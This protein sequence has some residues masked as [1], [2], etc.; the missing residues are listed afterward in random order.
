MAQ[1]QASTVAGILTTTGNVGIGITNPTARLQA[2]G[3]TSYNT[4]ITAAGNTSNG[5]GLGLLNANGH[6]WYL[7]S[8]GTGNGGGANNLGFYDATAGDYRVYF[9]GDGNVGINTT[10]PIQDLHVY[11]A[12]NGDG[13]LIE[14]DPAGV[15]RA[16]ALKLYPKAASANERNWAISPYK[17]VEQSLSFASSN[18]KGGDPYSA[19]TTRMIID[20]I[21]GNVGIGTATPVRDLMIG[22]LSSVSTATPKT[23]SLGGTYSNSAGENIKLR[24][25]EEPSA[26]GGMSVSGG[27][28]E[29]NTWSS[30]KIAFYRGTTQSMIIDTSGNVGIGTNNPRTDLHV[31]TGTTGNSVEAA[32]FT[33]AYAATGDGPLIR[34]TNFLSFATNPNTAEYNLAGI[35]AYDFASNWGGALQF[36]TAVQTGGGGNLTAAMTIDQTQQVGI[37]TVTPGY[38]FQVYND[39]DIWHTVIGGASG[40]LRIG[41]QTSSGAV[42]QALTPA[43]G[44]RDLYLQRDGGS[45][46]IGTNSPTA[47]LQINGAGGDTAPSLRIISAASDTFNWATD[48]RYA[49]LTVGETAIH[50]IGKANSQYNQAYFGYRH[51]SDG[52]ASNMLTLGMYA[53]DYLVNV[54]GN[55]NVGIGYTNP[56]YKLQVNGTG[57]FNETLFV[58]GI[59][60]IEDRMASIYDMFTGG[61]VGELRSSTSVAGNINFQGVTAQGAGATATTQQ[62][63]TWDINNY[64]GT[65]NYGVQA[66]LVVGNNGNVGT[67][68]GFFTS[69]NYGA[70]PVERLRIQAGGNV[71]I[72][73]TSPAYKLD[74][75]G[76]FRSN[77]LFTDASA[78]AFWGNGNT[79]TSY[80]LLT[81]DTG[82]A[83]VFATSGNRLDLGANGTVAA[84]INTSGNVGIGTTVPSTK[85]EVG[86]FLDTV[87]NKITVSARYEYEP[88]FNFKLGQSGTNF[89]WIG[90]VISS[91][92][93]D[94]YNGKILFKTAN[95]GRDTPTTKMVIKANGNVGIGT[96]APRKELDV[97]GNNL[98]V[99]A[100]R[101]ILGED[102]YSTS[103][104]YIG[105]KTSFQ[106]GTT[107]Y[108]IISGKSDGATYVSAKA[109]SPVYIRSGG[110]TSTAQIEVT[111]TY[112]KTALNLGIGT[113]PD[114]TL[115]VD[116]GLAGA[117]SYA[118]RTDAVSLDYALYVSSSGN[119][120]IGGLVPA[121]QL[122]HKLVVFS[123]SIALRGPNDPNFS[124][125]L[126][127]TAGTNRNALYVSS[128]NYLN[129]GNAAFAGL[130]LFHTGSAPGSNNI[131][132]GASRYYGTDQT[133]YLAEPNKW[134]AVRINN[135]DFVMPLYQ[136]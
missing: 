122:N 63:I 98:C 4:G 76:S 42:I 136:V 21:S 47:L 37:G 68:M 16:P 9:K 51:V 67:F 55:G 93:D 58:N 110:N 135:V 3:V 45:I 40:Q 39:T 31:W 73:T 24:V 133:Y 106:S 72:G 7:I 123:G 104:D 18:A 28:M 27:Q 60:T 20:G 114:G 97:Q 48:V 95:A 43:G 32:R 38:F 108:M 62:G 125:R 23:L 66:Q 89:N 25:Y 101:L 128:S 2:T 19:G 8:T 100:G 29:V 77:A 49:N 22:D 105:L 83:K 81:W 124:Y 35:R 5:V 127:D 11:A 82:I 94:N 12:G 102:A 36:L 80:G 34:F 65:T 86:N 115:H 71:G 15:N 111:D 96:I 120:A 117:A 74:V 87:T 112:A 118:L 54:L 113:V 57:Y 6:D 78:N 84:T 91:G 119:V 14:S 70:A 1:L 129:V 44:V 61:A 46:G 130:Q 85:L 109:G 41:G 33:G 116:S 92:D 75:V 69:D 126:N 107:D 90:A 30:G 50:L 17:D 103:A 26:I 53:S 56:A 131:D 59:T 88:E 13:I 121:A 64:N 10:S 99:V 79:A 132:S 52:S 134:L